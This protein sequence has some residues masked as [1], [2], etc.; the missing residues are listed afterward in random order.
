MTPSRWGGRHGANWVRVVPVSSSEEV[1][2]RNTM[3]H[4]LELPNH[5]QLRYRTNE[6]E[7]FR[8]V[9][10]FLHGILTVEGR[11]FEVECRDAIEERHFT[12][13]S[14]LATRPHWCLPYLATLRYE[15]A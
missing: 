12:P 9:E 1:L 4:S 6:T 8:I 2:D 15:G 5:A 7:G 13:Q 10:G 11:A 3:L 14:C